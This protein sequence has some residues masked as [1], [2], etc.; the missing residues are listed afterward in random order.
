LQWFPKTI[1]AGRLK[2]LF[3]F[4]LITNTFLTGTII[5]I[6]ITGR[7]PAFLEYWSNAVVIA[8][9]I[10]FGLSVVYYQL[11][12]LFFGT[13][14]Q[15]LTQIAGD[16]FL[17]SVLIVLTGGVDSAIAFVLIM[18]VINSSFLG[19]FKISIIGATLSAAA[20]A[21]IVDLHYYGYLPGM[22]ALGETMTAT[23]LALTILVNCGATYLVAILGG[24]LSSQLEFSSQ[25]LE[26]SQASFDRLSE[27]NDSIIQ[28]IDAALITTDKHGRILSI[29]R[30]GCKILKVS[31]DEV[32]GQ[33]WL[34]FFPELNESVPESE[35]RS[36]LSEGVTVTH[37]R[38]SDRLELV[39]EI[40]MMDLMDSD[41][42][43]WG[44]LLV[45]QDKTAL[46]RMQAE[47]KRSEHLAAL[48][49][50][51]AGLAHEIRTPL[52]A[53]SGSWNMMN[54][55]NL[56]QEDQK[57]LIV[58]IG[59]E[60]DRLG[61]LVNDFLAYAR[62]SVGNPQ[63][64]DLNHLINDQLHVFRSWKG[65]EVIITRELAEIPQVYF[66][67]SQ[68]TQVIFNLLQNAIEAAVPM[69]TLSLVVSTR[70]SEDRPGYVTLSVQDNGRGIPEDKI[71]NIFQP[72]YTTK[73][74]GTGLGLATVWGLIR[75][76]KGFIKVTSDQ[77][78]GTVFT[79]NLPIA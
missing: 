30:P 51:A 38:P 58:I 78:V 48:G 21:G 66:D 31:F 42:E 5:L 23:E 65:E 6:Y 1:V 12:P 10:C 54:N 29:N 39:L 8:M 26:T 14:V 55:H 33:P 22:P 17:A 19:G 15:I 2:W 45:L 40:S 16:T 53:M 28:S 18:V 35:L 59:R 77:I 41:N 74:K 71:K 32:R 34:R 79:I 62:P 67:Y 27:L 49:E 63:A 11:M 4:R 25:A 73:P 57:K 3:L 69:R 75:K 68:L 61:T 72:F 47:I 43:S 76:G 56:S 70:L 20:W 36:L 52:A 50:L 37:T 13:R 44:Q 46:S 60:M 9:I 7:V 64:I 24:Y